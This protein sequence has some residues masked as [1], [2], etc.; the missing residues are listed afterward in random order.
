MC[1]LSMNREDNSASLEIVHETL[2]DDS[3]KR[4][5]MNCPRCVSIQLEMDAELDALHNDDENDGSF[6]ET[7]SY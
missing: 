1:Y 2:P 7:I 4:N 3:P 5:S 6:S